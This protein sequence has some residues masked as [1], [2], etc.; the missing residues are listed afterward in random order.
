MQFELT[1]QRFGDVFME[2]ISV[3]LVLTSSVFSC[4]LTCSVMLASQFQ[5]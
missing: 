2:K 1:E 4:L 5:P 3:T